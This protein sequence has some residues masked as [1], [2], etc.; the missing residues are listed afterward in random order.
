[1]C[2][3]LI[4]KAIGRLLNQKIEN[5]DEVSKIKNELS[6]L[7]SFEPFGFKKLK[8]NRI[9]VK[10]AGSITDFLSTEYAYR[11]FKENANDLLN[12]TVIYYNYKPNSSRTWSKKPTKLVEGNVLTNH[13]CLLEALDFL[14]FVQKE[15]NRGTSQGSI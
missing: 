12:F 9:F 6:D 7:I 11:I 14:L 1:M 2:F 10:F 15:G 13:Q 8:D 3:L 4:L 5:D